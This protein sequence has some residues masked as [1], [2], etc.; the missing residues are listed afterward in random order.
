LGFW[1]RNILGAHTE[2]IFFENR[3]SI[4]TIKKVWD[5]KDCPITFLSVY[6][7]EVMVLSMLGF[8]KV[9]LRI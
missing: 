1:L 5:C 9:F 7:D 3:S 8:I 2:A 4:K 6:N